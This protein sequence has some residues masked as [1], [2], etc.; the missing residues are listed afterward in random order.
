MAKQDLLKN[1]LSATTKKTIG[2]KAIPPEPKEEISHSSTSMPDKTAQV[3]FRMPS[4]L[5]FQA[6]VTAMEMGKSLK[7]YI[8][9]LII[10]DLKRRG[11]TTD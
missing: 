9:N 3:N 5:R 1:K 7:D 11:K 8:T 10:E 4:N 2:K 6:K